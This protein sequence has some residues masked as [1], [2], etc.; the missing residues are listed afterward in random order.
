MLFGIENGFNSQRSIGQGYTYASNTSTIQTGTTTGN[1]TYGDT[2]T[3]G[4]GYGDTKSVNWRGIENLWGNI[5]CWLCGMLISSGSKIKTKYYYDTDDSYMIDLPF[6][7]GAERIL[8]LPVSPKIIGN[9]VI[10]VPQIIP[11]IFQI[12]VPVVR[13]AV[14]KDHISVSLFRITDQL[15][16]Q[17]VSVITL[18]GIDFS[19]KS[20]KPA[21]I[22]MLLLPRK[23]FLQRLFS[24]MGD[25]LCH[26]YTDTAENHCSTSQRSTDF[27][28]I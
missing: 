23:R 10:P 9:A 24:N 12:A 3:G 19:R 2:S 18:N 4:D 8:I 11:H 1:E 25:K 14:G 21:G 5:N 27:F 26:C 20:I 17:H 7:V 22:I 15:C 16:M 28:Y 13:I 6:S